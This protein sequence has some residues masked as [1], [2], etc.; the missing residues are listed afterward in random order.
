MTYRMMIPLSLSSSFNAA[1]AT[2]R[3]V[4]KE[5]HVMVIDI[6]FH[7]ASVAHPKLIMFYKQKEIPPRIDTFNMITHSCW[8]MLFMV[9]T[10]FNSRGHK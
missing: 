7:T 1:P 6:T 5:L 8:H 9:R 2:T 10:A 4:E 3:K